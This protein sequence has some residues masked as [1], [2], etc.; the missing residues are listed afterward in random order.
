LGI[1]K[2]EV[3]QSQ[4]RGRTTRIYLPSIPA[5]ELEQELSATLDTH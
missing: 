3:A 5:G 4:G 1:L 2:T